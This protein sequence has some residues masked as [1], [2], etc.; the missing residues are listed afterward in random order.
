MNPL[1]I[2]II[3]AHGLISKLQLYFF[4][5]QVYHGILALRQQDLCAS[6]FW[7]VG[8]FVSHEGSPQIIQTWTISA[9]KPMVTQLDPPIFRRG[10]TIPWPFTVLAMG[11][12]IV[13]PA[14]SWLSYGP[15]HY[16]P[17]IAVKGFLSV[18]VLGKK[19]PR[20]W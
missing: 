11:H 4:I 9:L 10:H 15:Y 14:T 18:G 12:G 13:T 8:G 17:V 19:N 5:S 2:Y 7:I 20:N 6:H 1:A 16:E 3:W